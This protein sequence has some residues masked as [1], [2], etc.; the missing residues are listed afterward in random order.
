MELALVVE[1]HDLEPPAEYGT[2][3]AA[4]LRRSPV[5]Q[6]GPVVVEQ[7]IVVDRELEIAAGRM[8]HDVDPLRAIA[9]RDAIH[10]LERRSRRQGLHSEDAHVE[11]GV[12]RLVQDLVRSEPDTTFDG[13]EVG[14]RL[15]GQQRVG[16]CGLRAHNVRVRDDERFIAPRFVEIAAAH[17]EACPD[18]DPIDIFDARHAATRIDQPMEP[19]DRFRAVGAEGLLQA[20]PRTVQLADVYAAAWLALHDPSIEHADE[21]AQSRLRGDLPDLDELTLRTGQL[22]RISPRLLYVATEPHRGVLEYP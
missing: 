2:A 12:R 7:K 22:E 9:Q 10:H 14:A 15:V 5:V 21:L 19:V 4:V 3:R 16:I 17:E 1:R 11:L 6:F 18:C 8:T 13:H 20:L